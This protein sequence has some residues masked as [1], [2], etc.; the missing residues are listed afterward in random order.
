MSEV[1]GSGSPAGF[2]GL[3]PGRADELWICCAEPGSSPCSSLI[4]GAAPGGLLLHGGCH[5]SC[6]R[7]FSVYDELLFR[8][9]ESYFEWKVGVLSA[10]SHDFS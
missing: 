2:G 6:V 8:W 10:K 5:L 4:I 1:P 3:C 7:P 9:G